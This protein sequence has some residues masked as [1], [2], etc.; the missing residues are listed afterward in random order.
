MFGV[1]VS[2]LSRNAEGM[3]A[4]T[5]GRRRTRGVPTKGVA[6]PQSESQGEEVE[7]AKRQELVRAEKD[8]NTAETLRAYL[9]VGSQK[10][11]DQ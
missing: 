4:A 3:G 1:S 9:K 11:D 7:Q 5:A 8:W 6:S 2:A 10:A